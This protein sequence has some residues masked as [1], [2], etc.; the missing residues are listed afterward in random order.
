VETITHEVRP[1]AVAG[2]TLYANRHDMLARLPIPREGLV[3]EV[4]VAR[5]DFSDFLIRQLRP[6]IFYAID[7]F[8]MHK[9]P[10]HW[11]IRQEVMFEGK[12]HGQFYRER[13][14]SL[15]QRISILHGRST[16]MIPRLPDKSLDMIY[17]DANHGYDHVSIEGAQSA[18]KIKPEGILIFNDYITY[19]PF[20][21]REYGVVRA[22]NEMLSTGQWRV[23]G[24]AL[25]KDMFC[26][27]AIKRA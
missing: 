23:V 3:A 17:I 4:G 8:E 5:G 19:D 26:D 10:V 16:D 12:T 22:V 6:Q 21:N 13:F 15:G 11:G 20:I 7:I 14:S 25:Q 24:F 2:A 9:S 18:G 1:E 27:I